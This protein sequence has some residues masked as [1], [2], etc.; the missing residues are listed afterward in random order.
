MPFLHAVR[1][2]TREITE[3]VMEKVLSWNMERR[4]EKVKTSIFEC[5]QSYAIMCC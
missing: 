3:L 5:A 2:L 4:V 1:K